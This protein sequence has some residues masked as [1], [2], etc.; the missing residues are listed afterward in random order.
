M[1]NTKIV[2]LNMAISDSQR[3]EINLKLDQMTV[4]GKTDGK[5]DIIYNTPVRGQQTIIREWADNAAAEEWLSFIRDY[6][7]ISAEIIL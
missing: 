2:L 4:E 5:Y 3:D 7:L 6:D 1:I